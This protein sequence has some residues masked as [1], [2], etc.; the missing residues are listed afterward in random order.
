MKG[1]ILRWKLDGNNN[2]TQFIYQYEDARG[3]FYLDNPLIGQ[4]ILREDFGDRHMIRTLRQHHL[5]E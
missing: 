4:R 2:P 1:G 5:L 3:T